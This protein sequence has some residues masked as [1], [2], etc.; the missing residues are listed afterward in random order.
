[1]L[2]VIKTCGKQYM[3]KPGDIINVDKIQGEHGAEVQFSEVLMLSDGEGSVKVGTPFVD[4]A[5]VN[6]IILGEKKGEK[7]TI[8]KF[9]RRKGYRK[10][11]GHRQRYTSVRIDSI[12][13]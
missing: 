11:T 8:F 9:R 1:M 2:A 13:G 5:L 10:K 4:G 12:N 3:V 7:L 6:G